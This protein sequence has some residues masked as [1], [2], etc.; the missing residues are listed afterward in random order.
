MKNSKLNIADMRLISLGLVTYIV[1]LTIYVA[2][3]VLPP[4][5]GVTPGCAITYN[6]S[7]LADIACFC[8]IR[9]VWAPLAPP[10]YANVHNYA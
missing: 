1:I 3:I 6:R 2:R 4:G 8:I 5:R 7:K 10:G 9:G